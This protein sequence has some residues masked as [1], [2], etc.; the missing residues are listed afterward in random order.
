MAQA[1]AARLGKLSE[2]ARNQ[3]VLQANGLTGLAKLLEA[4]D[5]RRSSPSAGR[6]ANELAGPRNK[7]VHV[8]IH[9]TQTEV[10]KAQ[11]VAK[12]LLNAYSPLPQP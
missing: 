10:K 4:I 5:G 11:E 6:I 7:A 8:G 2:A 1:L 12:G 9:P 3:I